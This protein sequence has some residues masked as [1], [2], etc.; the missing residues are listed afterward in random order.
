VNRAVSVR[1]QGLDE[2]RRKLRK[3]DNATELQSELKDANVKIAQFVVGRAQPLMMTHGHAGRVAGGTMRAKRI[4][5]A[6]QV[7]VASRFA[8]SAEFGAKHNVERHVG[9]GGGRRAYVR[10]GWNHLLVWRGNDENAGYSLFPVIRSGG[11]QILSL[12]NEEIAR[13]SAAAFPD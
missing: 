5:T 3:L 4:Q 12:Y 2:F 7:T 1:V 10:K 13:I 9:A 8:F 11:E 6:A